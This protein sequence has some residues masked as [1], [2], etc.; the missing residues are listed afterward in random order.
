[1][2]VANEHMPANATE[3]GVLPTAT[4][5]TPAVAV[6]AV[7]TGALVIDPTK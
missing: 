7:V 4:L 6:T 2:V 5:G 3:F 1:M